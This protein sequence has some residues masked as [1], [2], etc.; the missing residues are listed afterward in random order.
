V[1]TDSKNQPNLLKIGEVASVSGI[2][3]K[4]IRYY[5][6]LGLLTPDIS[7]NKVGYRLFYQSIFNRLSFIRRSQSL[8]L[9]LKEIDNIL[10]IYD[11]GEIPCGVAK[12]VLLEKL[13]NIEQQIEQLQILQSELKAILSG[14]QFAEKLEGNICPNIQQTHG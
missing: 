3:I 4:T 9:S 7:R 11:K 1:N 5:D 14:W 10:K 8:G 13:D 12:E 2:P 6:D